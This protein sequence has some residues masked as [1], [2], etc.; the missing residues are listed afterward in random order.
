MKAASGQT[1]LKKPLYTPGHLDFPLLVAIVALCAFGLVMLFSAS[2]YY[3]YTYK[4]DGFYY[5]KSQAMY[6]GAGLAAMYFLSRMNYHLF[7]K[8]RV[9]GLIAVLVLLV[10]V[11]VTG[12]EKNESQRWLEIPGTGIAFQPSEF[13]KFVLILY[14]ASFMARHPKR[15]ESLAHGI[16][17]MLII[18]AVVAV[19][20]LLQPNLSMTIIFVATGVVML[21]VGGAPL[22]YLLILVALGIPAVILLAKTQEYQWARLMIFLDPWD[23]SNP[24][25]D[26]YQL[27]QSLYALGSGGLFGQGLNFSRQKLLFLPY[28]ESDF[29]FAIIGE[30]LGFLGCTFVVAMYAFVAYRGMRIAIKCKDRFGSLLAAGITAVVALQAAVNIGVA[31]SS[32]PPTGQTLPLISHGGTSLLIFLCAFGILLN[33]SR[34]LEPQ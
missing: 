30:E 11:L 32:I 29:I 26:G 31:T 27:R 13:A 21:Y 14:M 15:M 34:N 18:M 8:L 17:P 7:E 23:T 24:K 33:I 16:A 9:F 20:L 28:G 6:C 5:L 2:Y 10:L 12:Q 1:E 22:K 19:L 3:A 4:G 25:V